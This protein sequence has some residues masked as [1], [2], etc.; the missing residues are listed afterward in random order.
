[1]HIRDASLK[2]KILVLT[3]G[4]IVLVNTIIALV[5]RRDIAVQAELAILEKSRAV[6][7]TA[8]AAREAMAERIDQGVVTDLD[9][10]AAQGDRAKLL[11]AVP[12]L[13]AIE[14]AS[15]NAQ[16]GDYSFRVPKFQPR[17]P[18]NEPVGPEIEALKALEAGSLEEYIHKD[19]DNVRYFRPIR[20]S[21]ECLLCHGD[22]AGSPDPIGGAKEGWKAGEVHGA[23][24]VVSSLSQAKRSVAAA[25]A[26]IGMFTGIIALCLGLGLF[27]VVR[28]VLGPLT[29]YMEVLQKASRGDLTARARKGR[30]DEVG[31]IAEHFNHYL[32][33]LDHIVAQVKEVTSSASRVSEDLAASSEETAASIHEIRI[34]TEGMKDKIVR[35]DGEVSGSAR[36]AAEVKLFIESLAGL[37]ANQASAINQSSA[38]IEQMSASI[39]NIAEAAEEKLRIANEL[40]ATALD[41][42]SE[43]EETERGIKKVAS[44]TSLILE[45]TQI[46]TDIASKTNLLAMN[47]AIEAA[48]AG[49]FGK[50]FA[51]VADEIRNLAE[52]SAESAKAVTRSLAEVAEFISLSDASTSRTGAIFDKIVEQIKG[53][54]FSM[55]EM[56]NATSE[57]SIGAKQILDALGSLIAT[58]EEVRGSSRDMS[59][60]IGAISEAM[61]RVSGISADTKIGM[62]EVTIGI[63]EIYKAAEA[64]SEA[65]TRN[66]DS[67]KDL[68][69]LIAQ[70]TVSEAAGGKA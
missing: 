60:R 39:A 48:H 52:S 11:K 24:E 43:M 37:I 69:A 50:G 5:F 14:V 66:S 25:T 17:N 20:L 62:E 42:Q 61:E 21:Q 67:V 63:N 32:S 3:I 47:A 70:F 64:I 38:S 16:A 4:S 45:M 31:K 44:S 56:K 23:F 53:V 28:V 33:T 46:I 55:S 8:E 18:Q 57:L 10:L 59:S 13:T 12:I 49:E 41:G 65:G 27:F 2:A 54:A 30:N 34:N 40:E 6:V 36:S 7:L 35:L 1:M 51:V 9:S 58:T 22:P 68:A 19:G 15:K 29:Q 26:N